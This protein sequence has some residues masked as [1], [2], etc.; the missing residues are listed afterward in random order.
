[1]EISDESGTVDVQYATASNRLDRALQL[2]E[3]GQE[4]L[5]LAEAQAVVDAAADLGV[6]RVIGLLHHRYWLVRSMACESIE[7]L[8]FMPAC[9]ELALLLRDEHPTVRSRARE[10]IESI[11]DY[12][13]SDEACGQLF[14]S[15]TR[16]DAGIAQGALPPPRVFVSYSRKDAAFADLLLEN[17]RQANVR[18]WIDTVEIADDYATEG[19]LIGPIEAGIRGSDYL[20]LIL[21]SQSNRSYWVERELRIARLHQS[22]RNPITV[23]ALVMDFAETPAALANYSPLFRFDFSEPQLFDSSIRQL[24]DRVQSSRPSA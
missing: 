3:E 23:M 13:L 8:N 20:A 2:V 12:R 15:V 10:A 4:A 11:H 21:S 7:D 9:S 18:A 14:E 16:R 19:K 17:L 22:R 1:L 6:A 5:L 24:I